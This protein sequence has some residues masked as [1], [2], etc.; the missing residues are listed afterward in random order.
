MRIFKNRWFLRFASAEG[1]D[2]AA[3]CKAIDDVERGLIDANLGGGV[4]KQRIAR[5]GEGTSGGFRSIVAYRRGDRAFFV[6][7][8]PKH[9]TANIKKDELVAFKKLAKELLALSGP[10]IEK[11]KQNGAL[12]EVTCNG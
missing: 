4:I 3:L 8:F 7:G 11:M 5:K 10:Q 12:T 6:F 1:I 9:R 2:N